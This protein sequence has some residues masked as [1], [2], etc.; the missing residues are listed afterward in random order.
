MQRKILDS[1]N[2]D[3][4]PVFSDVPGDGLN[5]QIAMLVISTKT[6]SAGTSRLILRSQNPLMKS[7]K[8]LLGL[9]NKDDVMT[10]PDITK[11]ISTPRYPPGSMSLLK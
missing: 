5:K 7:L 11:K 9:P 3:A 6:D 8:S 1:P 4:N 10:Y 2:N